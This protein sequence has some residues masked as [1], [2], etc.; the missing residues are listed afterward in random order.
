MP[1]YERAPFPKPIQN[2]IIVGKGGNVDVTTIDAGITNAVAQGATNSNPFM[3]LVMPGISLAHTP[4]DGCYVVSWESLAN[5]T[6]PQGLLRPLG[7]VRQSLWPDYS[8]PYPS[9]VA[10]ISADADNT[11]VLDDGSFNTAFGTGVEALEYCQL[12]GIPITLSVIP[13]LTA[14]SDP[15]AGNMTIA[16]LL[17]AVFAGGC[18]IALHGANDH[19]PSNHSTY[20][21]IQN[22]FLYGRD[23]IED[24]C[25]TV[26][27]GWHPH[28][29]TL[30]STS[31]DSL[32]AQ[33]M[34]EWFWGATGI[35]VDERPR[36]SRWGWGRRHYLT[37]T[38]T[39]ADIV[40]IVKQCK[41]PGKHIIMMH[42]IAEPG[43]GLQ[44]DSNVFAD[45]IDGLVL[46]RTAGE[47][48]PVTMSGLQDAVLT[49]Q[50]WLKDDDTTWRKTA[51]QWGGM[52]IGTLEMT[53]WASDSEA[54]RL[55]WGY[56]LVSR[57]GAATLEA[58]SSG[59][60]PWSA[61]GNGKV[62]Q[63]NTTDATTDMNLLLHPPNR[64]GYSYLLRVDCKTT[65]GTGSI[66]LKNAMRT[67][68]AGSPYG[69]SRAV[70]NAWQTFYFPFHVERQHAS[71]ADQ[72]WLDFDESGDITYQ[73]DNFE[74]IRI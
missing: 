27:R 59:L 18:E 7:S 40:E 74:A 32:L 16:D 42:G 2:V 73:V 54:T 70:S 11:W 64:A 69:L 71:S 12:A 22:M 10:I 66:R 53:A 51:L 72:I 23:W 44:T 17:I 25:L 36:G 49:P 57:G 58:G 4:V 50:S 20:A 61:G 5:Y 56:K 68:A 26:C 33:S 14:A 52:D 31:A 34:F 37:G 63:L 30:T 38:T 41:T 1:G 24:N 47:V 48:L 9:V 28:Y 62:L 67:T 60:W 13:G 21:E 39:A 6:G 19:A 8:V 43:S 45:L 55:S 29:T 15:P 65:V 46:A 3:I 35:E